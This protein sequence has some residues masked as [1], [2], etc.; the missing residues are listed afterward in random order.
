M[1]RERKS[2]R[3]P[4]PGQPNCPWSRTRLPVEWCIALLLRPQHVKAHP[5]LPKAVSYTQCPIPGIAIMR[6]RAG[7]T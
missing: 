5:N 3:P 7:L 1:L 6:R 2:D 4:P